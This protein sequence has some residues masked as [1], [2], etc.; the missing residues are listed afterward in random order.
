MMFSK[1]IIVVSGNINIRN[2]PELVVHIFKNVGLDRDLLFTKGPLDVLDHASDNF[3]FGGKAGVDATIK[4]PEETHGTSGIQASINV[5]N[6][7]I[8]TDYLDCSL[9]KKYNTDLYNAEMP[10]LILAVNRTEDTDV[11]EKVK[12]L[13]RSNNSDEVFKL[14][15]AVDHTVD[16]ADIHTVAWQLLGNSDP[17]RDHE[18][19][20]ADSL[21]LDGT[22]KAF[23]KGGFSRKWPNVVCSDSDIIT[24]IDQKW[25]SLGLGIIIE[26][27]SLK[28]HLLRRNGKDEMMIS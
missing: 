22:T 24:A 20:S 28:Y 7:M 10:V 1:Y 17:Q 25:I 13:L 19:L 9:I 14:V 3:S 5:E 11:L 27:P 21:F 4:H 8:K 16:P 2:Y 12:K 23:R 26:S 15:I 18:F 6:S